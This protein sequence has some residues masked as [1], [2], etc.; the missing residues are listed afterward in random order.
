MT[1]W[2]NGKRGR[3]KAYSDSTVGELKHKCAAPGQG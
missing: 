2:K 1:G 3:G